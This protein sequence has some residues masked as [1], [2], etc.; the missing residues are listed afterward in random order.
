MF[1]TIVIFFP[2]VCSSYLLRCFIVDGCV[3]IQSLINTNENSIKMG[4]FF[5]LK[6]LF[7]DLAMVLIC[8]ENTFCYLQY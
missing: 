2:Q 1:I 6:T 5:N 8:I 7:L 3:C 4:P